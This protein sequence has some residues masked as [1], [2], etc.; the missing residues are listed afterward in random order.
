MS[1]FPG[2]P[3]YPHFLDFL[4]ENGFPEEQIRN[5]THRNICNTFGINL[6][7]RNISPN[8]SLHSEYEVDVYKNTRIEK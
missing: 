8:K 6:P 1:G 4:R 3:F 2:L 7:E 5:L